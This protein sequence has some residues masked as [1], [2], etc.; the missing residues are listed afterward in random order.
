MT[1]HI[2]RCIE[3]ALVIAFLTLTAGAAM[4]QS[5]TGNWPATVTRSQR[6]NNTYC[7]K[8]TDNGSYG[9]P[10][11]GPAELNGMQDPYGAYFTVIDG[12][13]TVTFPSPS[14]EGDCCDFFVFT[15]HASDGTITTGAFNYFGPGDNGVVAFG[16]K[17]GC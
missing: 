2:R 8:L 3:M 16:K 17:N 14:G 12:L 4:A 9:R 1:R 5:Y 15:A 6:D 13:I 7:V 11:S 10:H